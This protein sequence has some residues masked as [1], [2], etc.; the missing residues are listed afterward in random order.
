MKRNWERLGHPDKAREA[1]GWSFLMIGFNLANLGLIL[2]APRFAWDFDGLP[3]W[4]GLALFAVWC[5]LSAYPQIRHVDEHIG[6][7]YPRRSWGAPILIAVVATILFL[8]VSALPAS[9]LA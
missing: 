5:C 8:A 2:A 7:T 9:A 1:F 6:E 3:V 4:V